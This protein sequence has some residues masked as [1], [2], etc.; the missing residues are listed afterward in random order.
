[1]RKVVTRV[2]RD[3]VSNVREGL[4]DPKFCDDEKTN[5]ST[6]FTKERFSISQRNE[7]H[8][9]RDG[10]VCFLSILSFSCL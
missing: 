1:M 8:L 5:R 4:R 10:T 3:V 7:E 6:G 9:I 2:L